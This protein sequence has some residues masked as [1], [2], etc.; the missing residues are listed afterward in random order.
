MGASTTASFLATLAVH[1]TLWFAAAWGLA[2]MLR[3]AVWRARL[4]RGAALGGVLSAGLALA[5]DT[6]RLEWSW[7][8]AASPLPARAAWSEAPAEG[9][10]IVLTGTPP[11]V[12]PVSETPQASPTATTWSWS[13][14]AVGLWALGALVAL[15]RLGRDRRRLTRALAARRPLRDATWAADLREFSG[16]AGLARAPRLSVAEGLSSPLALASGEVV[17]PARALREL[18]RDEQRALLAHEL[19]HLVRRDPHWLAALGVVERVFWFQPLLRA[20]SRRASAAAELCCDEAA[21]RWTGAGLALARCLERVAGWIGARAPERVAVA[22][23]ARGSALVERVERLLEPRRARAFEGALCATLALGLLA[24]LACSGPTAREAQDVDIAAQTEV[25]RKRV[26]PD[27]TKGVSIQFL[28]GDRFEIS[29]P[30]EIKIPPERIA[31]LRREAELRER[32]GPPT[33]PEEVSRLIRAAAI[34]QQPDPETLAALSALG[35]VAQG[36]DDAEIERVLARLDECPE[37]GIAFHMSYADGRY[38][39][40]VRVTTE[41]ALHLRA[42]GSIWCG[43]MLLAA[44]GDDD[45]RLLDFHLQEI[46]RCARAV[47][48]DSDRAPPRLDVQLHDGVTFDPLRRLLQSAAR[49]E[50]AITDFRFLSNRDGGVAFLNYRLPVDDASGW[51]FGLDPLDVRVTVEVDARGNRAVQVAL[52]GPTGGAETR[53]THVDAEFVRPI[54][55]STFEAGSDVRAVIDV[56]PGV[57]YRDVNA[58]LDAL[59]RAGL[60]HIAFVGR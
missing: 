49:P 40:S 48:E 28:G 45:Q 31:E 23:A 55:E 6:T 29:V 13:E 59:I 51:E 39:P 1:A 16:H 32:G 34:D 14:V 8:P 56:G 43:D 22:M 24:A 57:L 5:L 38:A 7:A 17:V 12:A 11:A 36:T 42:D 2:R 41:H 27:G 18:A 46:A 10:P 52:K 15:A 37:A 53:G 58:L 33:S 21:A 26:D 3:S 54:L 25:I 60:T 20:A 30:Y 19:A 50:A 47:A 35:Y 44:G 9:A 4:W